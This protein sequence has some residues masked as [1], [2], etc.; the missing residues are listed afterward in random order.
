MRMGN[1]MMDGRGL[2][3]NSAVREVEKYV[4]Q[5][6]FFFND[7]ATTEIYT[8]SLHDAL[9]ISRCRI[10]PEAENFMDILAEE[11]TSSLETILQRLIRDEI[12]RAHV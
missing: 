4:R 9:P 10:H 5:R 6:I 11:S 2:Q 7:T 3:R 1:K 8:L 12:G